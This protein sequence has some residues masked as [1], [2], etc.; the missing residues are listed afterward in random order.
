MNNTF[1]IHRFSNYLKWDLTHSKNY[2]GLSLL[3]VSSILPIFFVLGQFFSYLFEKEFT[4]F[5]SAFQFISLFLGMTII[6]LSFPVKVYGAL[7][8]KKY[9]SDWLMTPASMLEK[10]LSIIVVTAVVLPFIYFTIFLFW[11]S[12]LSLFFPQH[13]S[14]VLLSMDD[15]FDFGRLQYLSRFSIAFLFYLSFVS[16][17]LFYTLG[18]IFFKKSKIAKS[19]LVSFVL[20]LLILFICLAFNLSIDDTVLNGP[21]ADS[22]VRTFKFCVYFFTLLQIIIYSAAIHLRIRTLKH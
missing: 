15:V 16:N 20:G 17:I 21:N 5:G 10:T 4:V 2:Y 18:A 3:I 1:D 14:H 12:A 11:D 8:E 19:I 7:T 13:Y 6:M 9:G 22:I